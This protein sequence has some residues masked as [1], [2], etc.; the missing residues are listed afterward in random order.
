[1][2]EYV[3]MLEEFARASSLSFHQ[4]QVVAG[5]VRRAVLTLPLGATCLLASVFALMVRL[6]FSR[7]RKRT[8][9]AE[10]ADYALLARLLRLNLGRGFYRLD[11]FEGGRALALGDASKASDS[12]A[13]ATSREVCAK[14]TTTSGMWAKLSVIL[15]CVS[16][17]LWRGLL[18]NFG[19]G[20]SSLL[21][22]WIGR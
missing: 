12:A 15:S 8:T 9:N 14:A 7:A 18:I 3:A 5:C 20:N 6:M 4:R 2:V 19:V 11:A 13:V 1:M 21:L 17:Y 10:R 16:C 22:L